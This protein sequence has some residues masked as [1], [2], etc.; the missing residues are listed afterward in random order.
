[1]Q[2][3]I[4]TLADLESKKVF[5]DWV[6]FSIMAYVNATIKDGKTDNFN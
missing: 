1:M 2:T 6:W 3:L 4:T 5:P